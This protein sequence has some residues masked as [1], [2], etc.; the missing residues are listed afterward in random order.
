MSKNV[1][2]ILKAEAAK[3]IQQNMYP[4]NPNPNQNYPSQHNPG[5]NYPHVQP[6][7]PPNHQPSYQHGV[8]PP[9]HNYPP[10]SMVSTHPNTGYPPQPMAYH[11]SQGG[12]MYPVGTPQPG[13]QGYTTMTQTSCTTS[14]IE[15]LNYAGQP[16]MPMAQC[17]KVELSVSCTSLKNKDLFSK[18]D[19]VCVLYEKR[20]GKWAEKDK[21]EMVHNNLNPQ[22]QKKF[23]LD[24][25]PHVPQEIKFEIYDWDTKATSTAK[26]DFLGSAEVG[27]QKLLAENYNKGGKCQL[28]LKDGGQGKIIIMAEE[29]KSFA[30]S[31]VKMQFMA[32]NLD[33]KDFFG[34]SDPYY[35]LKKKMPNGQ[36]TLVYKSEF[37][38]K[39]LNPKWNTMEKTVNEICSGD[40]DRELKIEVFDHDKRGDDDL[41]GE[42]VTSL[43]SLM[44]GAANRVEYDVLNFERKRKKKNYKNSGTISVFHIQFE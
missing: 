41:I 15:P 17:N 23:S 19:P 40:Y 10:Q 20:N 28:L 2:K 4:T 13:A 36:W 26:Q 22:W 1:K 27:I 16:M 31:K 42:L 35:T 34:A 37:V 5:G 7:F 38:E 25:N 32:H 8:Y 6:S 18:S 43:R 9:A 3:V 33:K 21:T 39:D 24:Y 11:T 44:A 30:N 14:T 12:N 29:I